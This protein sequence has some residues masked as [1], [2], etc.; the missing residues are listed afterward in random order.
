MRRD[1]AQLSIVFGAG[2]AKLFQGQFI[3]LNYIFS[4]DEQIC[5]CLKKSLIYW[6]KA[7][8]REKTRTYSDTVL[9]L[10]FVHKNCQIII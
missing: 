8:D 2:E 10:N 7:K 1:R 9:H 5:L 4:F 3:R 6:S